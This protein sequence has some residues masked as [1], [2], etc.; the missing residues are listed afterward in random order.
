MPLPDLTKE[1]RPELVRLI[2]EAIDGDRT[3]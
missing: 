2:R 3:G 1:E